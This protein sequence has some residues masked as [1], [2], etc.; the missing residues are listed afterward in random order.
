MEK[1]YSILDKYKK[2]STRLMDILI[3]IQSEKGFI[4]IPYVEAISEELNLSK[5]DVEQTISFYHFFSMEPRGKYTVYLNDSVVAHMMGRQE[6]A[7]TFEK[8][9]G[10]KF[11]HVSDDGIIG[12]FNTSCIG[13]NDQEPAAIINEAVFTRLTPFRVKELV[14]DMREGKEVEEMFV[15]SYGDGNNSSEL[16]KAVVSNNIRKKGPILISDFVPGDAIRKIIQLNPQQVINE[17]KISNMRGRGGA[18]FPT[19]LKWEFCR[20]TEDFPKYIFCNADEGEP[21]TFKDRVILTEHPKMI[22]EGMVVAAYAVGAEEGLLYLRH[23]YKYLQRHLENALQELRELNLLG[24]NIGEKDG[25]AFDIRIQFGAGAYVCGEESAL[26]ESAEGKR[27]EPRD[28]PPFPVEK[29]YL[30][31][32]TIVNNVETLCA[33]VKIIIKGGEWYRTMGTTESAGTKVLSISGDCRN[34][35]VYEVEWGFNV[36]DI[37][38]MVGADPPQAIQVGGPSGSLIGPDEF[39]RILGYEDLATGGSIIVIGWQRDILRDVVLNFTNF[40]IEESCGSCTPCRVLTVLYKQ[41]LEKILKGKGVMKDIEDMQEWGKL[42]RTSRCGLGHTA[43]NPILSSTKNF[44]HLYE[45]RIQKH[46]EF[47]SGFD[48]HQAVLESCIVTERIPNLKSNHH[49]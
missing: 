6:V 28:R 17:M 21:G 2:D 37:L 7:N 40:F 26:I 13:M 23:E 19:G 46:K 25:F 44:R 1:L 43:A 45:S 31:K 24:N 41:K 9:V 42:M 34:P 29:G 22:F 36:N 47:D 39:N 38:D 32:P 49:E 30:N 33:A 5:A 48:L 20:K 18:G 11:G 3:D 35:G 8:E 4:P 27:G 10:C 15:A 16:I 12:L 14:R